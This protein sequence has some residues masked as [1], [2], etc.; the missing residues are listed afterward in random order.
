M[1]TLDLKSQYKHLYKPS[2]K[3]VQVVDVPDLAFLMI[4]GSIGPGEAPA[5]ANDFQQAM[6]ALYGAAYTIKFMSKQRKESPIDYPVMA[7]EGLWWVEGGEFDFNKKD[8]WR[9]TLMIMAPDHITQEM[10]QTALR[11]LEQ[12]KR[13]GPA[14]ARLRLDRFCE[15]LCMQIMHVGPYASEP[16]TIDRMRA[17]AQENGYTYRGKHH[18]IYLGDPRRADPEKLQTVMRQP[19][20]QRI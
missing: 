20:Q 10:F 12:K 14:L 2:A 5:T 8:N 18:E 6:E 1:A 9:F 7:L 4:D 3:A 15:G 11:Q 13:G 19:I 17:F 16:Q